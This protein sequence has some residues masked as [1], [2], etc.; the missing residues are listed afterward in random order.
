MRR[1]ITAARSLAVTIAAN[2]RP[3]PSVVSASGH[4]R[5]PEIVG[6]PVNV[7]LAG[8]CSV[9]HHLTLYLMIGRSTAPISARIAAAR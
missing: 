4:N 7:M 2:P 5:L 9:F 3:M 8:W 6:A 1:S